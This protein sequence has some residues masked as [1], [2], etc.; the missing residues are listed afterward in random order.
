VDGQPRAVTFRLVGDGY[1]EALG[2]PVL[3][4]RP[5]SASEIVSIPGE[6]RVVAIN[7]SFAD[8]FFPDSEPSTLGSSVR[9]HAFDTPDLLVVAVVGDVREFGPASAPRP[10]VYLPV[11]S[12]SSSGFALRADGEG[13]ADP[14]SL[15]DDVRG[16]LAQLD[17]AQ[18]AHGFRTFDSVAERWLGTPAFQSSLMSVF[19]ALALAL[20]AV[21]VFGAVGYA[22][23]RRTREIGL[24]RALGARPLQIARALLGEVGVFL[25]GGATAGALGAVALSRFLRGSLHGV[26][27]DDPATYGVALALIGGAVVVAVAL[28]LRRAFRIDPLE[29]LR[30][31]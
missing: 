25:A 6:A 18:P 22:M 12:S 16:V 30:D 14:R 31:S 29:A 7:R 27:P 11:A 26:E 15:F 4:G 13:G 19:A 10:T 5:F 24:R 20:A 28:P 17:P 23:R 1:F 3:E 2:I 21:G 8:R 9:L